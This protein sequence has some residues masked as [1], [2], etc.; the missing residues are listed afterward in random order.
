M[1]V[2]RKWPLFKFYAFCNRRHSTVFSQLLEKEAT[3][4]VSDVVAGFEL[5]NAQNSTVVD[6]RFH[7][8][9]EYHVF[10]KMESLTGEF[11]TSLQ[12]QTHGCD[13]RNHFVKFYG[14]LGTFKTFPTRLVTVFVVNLNEKRLFVKV[15][16]DSGTKP[17][18]AAKEI[19]GHSSS[20]DFLPG[21]IA[22][23][24]IMYFSALSI[25]SSE[26]NL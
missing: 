26:L 6:S 12:G 15:D 14:L 9:V 21:R 17:S 1:R 5:Q 23:G 11:P 25:T 19:E 3:G 4:S 2:R 24:Q 20:N 18:L 8:D 22:E 7:G 16:A 10:Y 13:D